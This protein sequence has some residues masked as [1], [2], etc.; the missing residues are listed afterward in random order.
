MKP[1]EVAL[2]TRQA[3]DHIVAHNGRL[4]AERGEIHAQLLELTGAVGEFLAAYFAPERL[5]PNPPVRTGE[6]V[7]IAVQRLGE[8]VE[9]EPDELE[10]E[11]M[12]LEVAS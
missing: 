9:V 7:A 2:P 12:E 3:F 11:Q 8:L 5:G 6:R 10:P 4:V 1:P